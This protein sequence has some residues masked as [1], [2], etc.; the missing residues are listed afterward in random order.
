MT[1]SPRNPP[2]SSML[3]RQDSGICGVPSLPSEALLLGVSHLV[4]ESCF[5]QWFSNFLTKDSPGGLFENTGSWSMF[6]EFLIQ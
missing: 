1:I 4:L 5:F 2:K 3:K 6:P